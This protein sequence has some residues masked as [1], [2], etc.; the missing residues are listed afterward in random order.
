MR[1]YLRNTATG[2]LQNRGIGSS[3]ETTSSRM[4]P[5]GR[6]LRAIFTQL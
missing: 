2:S 4:A 5:T 3:P 6:T 1:R